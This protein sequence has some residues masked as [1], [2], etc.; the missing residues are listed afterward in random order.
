M[1]L[2][3]SPRTAGDTDRVPGRAVWL[4]WPTTTFV[5]LAYVARF[6]SPFPFI[7]DLELIERV[8]LAKTVAWDWR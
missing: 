2:G 6:A 8:A 5:A 3:S 1:V 4:V 7:D